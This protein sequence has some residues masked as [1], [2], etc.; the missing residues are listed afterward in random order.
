MNNQDNNIIDRL[1]SIIKE[2]LSGPTKQTVSNTTSSPWRSGK[3]AAYTNTQR[4]HT[5]DTDRRKETNS[6]GE[7]DKDNMHIRLRERDKRLKGSKLLDDED[8]KHLE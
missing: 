4:Q 6:E 7:R 1:E 8:P 2:Q 3:R 5:I